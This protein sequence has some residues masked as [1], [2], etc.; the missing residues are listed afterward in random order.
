MNTDQVTLNSA[1]HAAASAVPAP[2]RI[3]LPLLKSADVRIDGSR[4]WL[5]Q[6]GG[7][8]AR[9][10]WGTTVLSMTR[11]LLEAVVRRRVGDLANVTIED[12]VLVDRLMVS[13]S[14]ATGVEVPDG[15]RRYL[16]RLSDITPFIASYLEESGADPKSHSRVRR[17]FRWLGSHSRHLM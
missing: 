16:N 1:R 8:R 10:D 5:F 4:A 7:Y 9:G 15:E 11:P 17:W 14:T 13:G 12:G 6:A 2:P 3:L